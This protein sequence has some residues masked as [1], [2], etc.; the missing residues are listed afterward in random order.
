[1]SEA[2]RIAQLIAALRDEN[3]ALREHAMASLGQMGTEAIPPLIGLMADEDVMIREAAAA[4]VLR[5][6]PVAFDQLVE[7]LQDDEW[8]IR[9]QAANVLGRFRD[10]RAVEPLMGA[11]KDK[12]G[13]VR[14]AA[15]CGLERIG[16]SSATPGL[17]EA[18]NDGT[19]RED[20]ARVLKKNRRHQGSGCADRRVVGAELD[21]APPCGGSLGK[22]RRSAKRRCVDPVLT[23]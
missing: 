5:I 7:A 15:V 22:N 21:G 19:V 6:G 16:D 1:M 17:I 4:A 10:A 3:E 18:L 8:A 9:E 23:G 14:T 20:V 11:L 13:A 12:D 2:D